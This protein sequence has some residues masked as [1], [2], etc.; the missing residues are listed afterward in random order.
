MTAAPAP[1]INQKT[2]PARRPLRCSLII[3]DRREGVNRGDQAGD[4][5]GFGLGFFFFRVAFDVGGAIERRICRGGSRRFLR[6]RREDADDGSFLRGT[7]AAT[8]AGAGDVFGH[9]LRDG[10]Q[11]ADLEASGGFLSSPRIA[12]GKSDM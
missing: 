8:S 6:C 2:K 3:A 4:Y 9:L 11:G 10:A 7:R 1:F 5:W 12:A